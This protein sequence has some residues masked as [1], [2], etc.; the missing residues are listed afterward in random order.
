MK[1]GMLWMDLSADPLKTR[2][3]RAVDYYCNKY[4]KVP[5]KAYINPNDGEP[6]ELSGVTIKTTHSVL[7]H[8]I[9]IGVE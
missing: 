5:N 3:E 8:H 1:I 6:C 7:P 2:L 9:W 4:G